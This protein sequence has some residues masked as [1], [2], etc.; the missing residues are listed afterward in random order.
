L[1]AAVRRPLPSRPTTL[2]LDGPLRKSRQ[3]HALPREEAARLTTRRAETAL[4][5]KRS[6]VAVFLD[7]SETFDA[8]ASASK[9]CNL[10]RM[11]S[12]SP[13][14]STCHGSC[15]AAHRR[16]ACRQRHETRASAGVARLRRRP[17]GG[18]PG[19]KAATL[20]GE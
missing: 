5:R 20:A 2:V 7:E 12:R 8:P 1:L 19:T 4:A 9:A 16:S 13:I 15:S 11:P 17:A 6:A 10:F 14:V 18:A 3:D